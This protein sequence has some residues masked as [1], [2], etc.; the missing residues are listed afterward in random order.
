MKCE[1]ILTSAFKKELKN[2]KKHL[3]FWQNG[4]FL[5]TLRTFLGIITPCVK[6]PN[7]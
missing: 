6:R 5:V 3:Y 7:Q 1:I 2:I 4:L